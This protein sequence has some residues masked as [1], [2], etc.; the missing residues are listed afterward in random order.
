MMMKQNK[1]SFQGDEKEEEANVPTETPQINETAER[2]LR[3][4]VENCLVN[5]DLAP[6]LRMIFVDPE[7]QRIAEGGVAAIDTLTPAS[8]SLPSDLP[9]SL[10][11]TNASSNSTGSNTDPTTSSDKSE[12]SIAN[13]GGDR[14][15][16]RRSRLNRASNASKA[17]SPPSTQTAQL[18][19]LQR[20]L[21]AI[22]TAQEMTVREVSAH[23]ALEITQSVSELRGMT[24]AV[25]VVRKGAIEGSD[26]LAKVGNRLSESLN[27]LADVTRLRSH[28]AAARGGVDLLRQV[29]SQLQSVAD[30]MFNKKQLFQ[31]HQLLENTRREK[32]D[33]IF[34][35][36]SLA[37]DAE[38]ASLER[39]NDEGR[40]RMSHHHH[41]PSTESKEKR[42]RSILDLRQQLVGLVTALGSAVEYLA[43]SHLKEWFVAVRAA[44]GVVGLRAVRQSAIRR[45]LDLDLG[46]ERQLV[47]AMLLEKLE[48]SSIAQA[49]L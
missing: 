34:Q 22:A 7:L 24:N 10:S 45:Q 44:A 12:S 17:S 4:M 38:A 47:A 3:D 36:L 30:L 28:V 29:I 43:I 11:E 32:L 31:A 46:K 20:A 21:S 40:H 42:R 41:H 26:A 13:K 6:L 35:I 16:N 2:E 9:P 19:A 37:L 14:S 15:N 1:V 8:V 48:S 23:R 49:L 18:A 33:P 39:N 5:N 25:N 27:V